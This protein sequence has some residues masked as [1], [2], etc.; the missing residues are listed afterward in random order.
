[1]WR[2]VMLMGFLK[3]LPELVSDRQGQL[4]ITD[5]TTIVALIVSSAV[6]L[7]CAYWNRAP[8]DALAVYV[9]AWVVHVGVQKYHDR[10]A[11]DVSPG[12]QEGKSDERGAD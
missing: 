5:A 4:S 9:S 12:P 8:V 1:M 10:K 11:D 3:C 2:G 6:V 7:M